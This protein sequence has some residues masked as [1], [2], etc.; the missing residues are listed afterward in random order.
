MRIA[1][2]TPSVN[3]RAGTQKCV[4]WMVEDLSRYCDLT[5]FT[6]EVSDTDVSRCQVHRLPRLRRPRLAAYLMFLAA[7]ALALTW[8]RLARRPAFDLVLATAGDCAHADIVWAHFCCAA[9][10]QTWTGEAPQP[11]TSAVHK[12]K[13]LHYRAFL[14]TASVIERGLYRRARLRT[15]MAVS[16]GTRAELI[17]HYGIDAARITVVPNAADDRVRIS[18]PARRRVRAEVRRE[19]QIPDRARVLLFVAAGDWKRK[20]LLLVFQALATLA[21]PTVRLLV[22]GRDDVAYYRAQAVRLGIEAGVSFTG[23]TDAIERYYAAADIFVYPSRYEAFSL[24][25][26]EAAAAGLPLLLTRVNGVDELLRP[27]ENGLLIEP[28]A[29]DIARK[30]R[31]LLSN[32]VRLEQMAAAARSSSQSFTRDAVVTRTLSLFRSVVAADA[33]ALA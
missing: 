32:P 5:L 17:H 16:G 22:V 10:L 29:D 28:D 6:A 20:G 12:L 13:A 25:T 2:V 7:N 14:W 24:V 11:S 3:R 19:H 4:S 26:L 15:V 23:F 31:L 30:L 8:H 33:E 9:W 1:L 27:G 21:D 18:P